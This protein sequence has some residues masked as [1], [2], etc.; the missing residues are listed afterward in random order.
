M[1]WAW[2]RI[3]MTTTIHAE[4]AIEDTIRPTKLK[5]SLVIQASFHCVNGVIHAPRGTGVAT[6]AVAAAI[7]I[8]IILTR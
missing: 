8:P 2:H 4:A 6:A 1:N 7:L 3:T 5:T